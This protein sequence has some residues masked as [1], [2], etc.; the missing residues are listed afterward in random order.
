MALKIKEDYAKH[1]AK[2]VTEIDCRI[3]SDEIQKLFYFLFKFILDNKNEVEL[4]AQLDLLKS[5]NCLTESEYKAV[6]RLIEHFTALRQK[7]G[8]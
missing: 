1:L 6:L 4:K 5:W 8:N 2:I 3:T 7:R